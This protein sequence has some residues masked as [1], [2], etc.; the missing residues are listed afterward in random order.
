M[1]LRFGNRL[2]RGQWATFG[3]LLTLSVGMMGASGTRLAATVRSDVNFMLNPV[4]IWI[5][6]ATDTLGSYW[7]TL[8]QLDRLRSENEKLREDNQTL[9]EEL[10]RMPAIARL[11]DDW[12]KISQA[13]QTSPYQT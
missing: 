6:G 8:T 3:L 1:N 13:P 12:T 9:K 7:S 4:E 2:P 11:N 5:N 10:A